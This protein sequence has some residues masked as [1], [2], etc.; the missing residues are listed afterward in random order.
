[1]KKVSK[2]SRTAWGNRVQPEGISVVW[3]RKQRLLLRA[4][5][6]YVAE[7]QKGWS[8][9]EGAP[10][11]LQFAASPWPNLTLWM[12]GLRLCKAQRRTANGE[13]KAKQQ[14]Q[15]SQSAGDTSEFWFS[16]SV[17]S[18]NLRTRWISQILPGGPRRPCL[19]IKEDTPGIRAK[20][21]N[22]LP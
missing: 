19:G 15:W 11:I 20:L 9:R 2:P 7:Y 12:Y 4:A 14:F 17:H 13:L 21:N 3:W 6:M 22:S 16:Q 10:E 1:M 5:K 8:C 18:W